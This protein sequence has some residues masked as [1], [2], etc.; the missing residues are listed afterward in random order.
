MV[1]SIYSSAAS[2]YTKASNIMKGKKP[3]AED[4][5]ERVALPSASTH[6]SPVKDTGKPSFGELL[7]H[8]IDR[9]IKA[10]YQGEETSVKTLAKKAELH[11]M[12]TAVTNAELTLQT[13]VAVRDKVINAYQDI[14]KMPI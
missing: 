3:E 7:D 11:E 8:S 1:D 14:L 13:V 10:Q 6:P 5:P 2:A 12:V 4:A 9:G